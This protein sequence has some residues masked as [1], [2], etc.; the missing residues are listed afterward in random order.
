MSTSYVQDLFLKIPADAIESDWFDAWRKTLHLLFPREHY[1]CTPPFPLQVDGLPFLKDEDETAPYSPFT[2]TFANYNPHRIVIFVD[3]KA[4]YA[5]HDPQERVDAD[6]RMYRRFRRYLES[7]C[8]STYMTGVS[9]FG[10]RVAFYH[11]DIQ[12]NGAAALDLGKR[13]FHTVSDVPSEEWWNVD[14]QQGGWNVFH[15]F[16]SGVVSYNVP[17]SK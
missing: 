4:Q 2:V 6:A 1:V 3:V 17:N 12:R 5:I 14:L 15:K 11:F 13:S 7:G 9:A 10:P 16:L 8:S